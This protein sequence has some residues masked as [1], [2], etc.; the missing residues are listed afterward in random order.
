MSPPCL[1]A[2]PPPPPQT[3]QPV[4]DTFKLL[5]RYGLAPVR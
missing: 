4:L 5:R 1:P 2:Q 3:S